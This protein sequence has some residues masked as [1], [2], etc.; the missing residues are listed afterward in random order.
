MLT[1]SQQDMG[2]LYGPHHWATVRVQHEIANA[3]A[4]TIAGRFVTRFIHVTHFFVSH[5]SFVCVVSGSGGGRHL[6]MT[7]PA[8]VV[9]HS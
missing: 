7:A 9:T 1:T 2:L 4:A 3:L 6:D 8:G 5:D